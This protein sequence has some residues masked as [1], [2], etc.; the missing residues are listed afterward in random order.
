MTLPKTSAP[1]SDGGETPGLSPLVHGVGDPV[2]PGV[3]TDLSIRTR[4]Y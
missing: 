4:G 1:L 3:A 2:E